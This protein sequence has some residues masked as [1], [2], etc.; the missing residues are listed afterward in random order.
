MTASTPST[1]ASRARAAG[2]PPPVLAA[3]GKADHCSAHSDSPL[4]CARASQPRVPRATRDVFHA[5]SRSST[6]AS[7]PAPDS[8]HQVQAFT[9][10]ASDSRLTDRPLEAPTRSRSRTCH[11]TGGTVPS[12]ESGM[13]ANRV[14]SRPAFKS[15]PDPSAISW[16]PKRPSSHTLVT[17]RTQCRRLHCPDKHT[18]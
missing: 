4:V 5:T 18:A 7:L 6:C 11:P 2:I 13:C 8:V 17:R 15:C 12:P 14:T 9:Q 16:L 1:C 10:S 3:F